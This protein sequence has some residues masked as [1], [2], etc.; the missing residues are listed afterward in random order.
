[1]AAS[2]SVTYLARHDEAADVE[3]PALHRH[4]DGEAIK[5]N[6]IHQVEPL[7]GAA[8]AVVIRVGVALRPLGASGADE[9]QEAV[10]ARSVKRGAV[11]RRL[12]RPKRAQPHR[13]Y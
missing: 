7:D 10:P 2:I 13:D 4:L 9:G 1:M 11:V 6:G 12:R 5:R 8:L 3:D